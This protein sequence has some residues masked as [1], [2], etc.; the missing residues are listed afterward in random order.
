[1]IKPKR[2]RAGDN[3]AVLSPS[4]GLPS[5]FPHIFDSG[6]R[7][8]TA[9]GLNVV[10]YPTARMDIADVFNNPQ[11]RADD[12]NRAFSDNNI[13]GIIASIGGNDSARILKYLDPDIIKANPKFFMGF[14]DFTAV[15]VFV[16]QLGLVTFNGPSIMAGFSQFHSFSSEYQDYV[17]S[18]LFN[19]YSSRTFPVFSHYSD[20]YPDWFETSN[21]GKL[22][23]Q[24]SNGG[25]RFIQS[26]SLGHGCV[27]GQL[28]GGC[29]EVLEM[30]KGTQYWPRA[31]FWQGKILFFETSE[32]KPS[33][34]YV[35][36]WLRNYGV[37][38][39]FEQVSGILFG[40]ARDYSD[41]EKAQLDEVIVSVVAGEFGCNEL[42][43]VSNLDFG[44]TDPQV[45][46]P[47]GIM[48]EINSDT[49]QIRLLESP[50][51]LGQ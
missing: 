32:E 27:S 33:I 21:E 23:P 47:Q 36:Y 28:F 7:N 29:I 42:T 43:L 45:I 39:A 46:L 49:K 50:F 40:R 20:G 10:E 17:K 35:K 48:T 34:D 18:F 4:T 16:N 37:M 15:S 8:L 6:I 12:I 11:M 3:I 13:H 22:H 25:P 31:N 24:K 26:P 2:L 38:G 30:L 44:H 9:L 5:V 19:E 1:M 51:E 14:S 41:E